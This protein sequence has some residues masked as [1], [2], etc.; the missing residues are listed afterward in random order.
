MNLQ[1]NNTD[2]LQTKFYNNGVNN[3]YKMKQISN[4]ILDNI[5]NIIKKF[6]FFNRKQIENN[7]IINFYNS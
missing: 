1:I 5:D 2:I 6:N 3:D 7:D 4:N